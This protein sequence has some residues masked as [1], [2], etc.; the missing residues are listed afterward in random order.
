[1]TDKLLPRYTDNIA[2]DGNGDFS[3]MQK[4]SY[5][6]YICRDELKAKL[7]KAIADSCHD[8]DTGAYM[9]VLEW[10]GDD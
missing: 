7:E 10:L 9:T 6:S 2:N 5:G 1:M 3:E 4:C 8:G